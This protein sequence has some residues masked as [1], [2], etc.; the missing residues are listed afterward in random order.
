MSRFTNRKNDLSFFI[1]NDGKYI[2]DTNYFHGI[3]YCSGN[4]YI[5]AHDGTLRL[6]LSS[7]D[8]EIIPNLSKISEYVLDVLIFENRIEGYIFS[9]YSESWN[10]NNGYDYSY[11]IDMMPDMLRG[12][13]L[14]ESQYDFLMYGESGIVYEGKISVI[15]HELE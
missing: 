13:T 9:G 12:H 8:M 1:I 5:S 4:S 2:K 14:T 3:E 10:E 15:M 7:H 11:R 6:L